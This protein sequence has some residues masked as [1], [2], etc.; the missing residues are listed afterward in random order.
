MN[1]STRKPKAPLSRITQSALLNTL[2]RY[3]EARTTPEDNTPAGFFRLTDTKPG[4]RYYLRFEGR[5]YHSKAVI[6]VALKASI[7]RGVSAKKFSGGV[8]SI[9]RI[10]R[11]L[12]RDGLDLELWDAKEERVV[13]PAGEEVGR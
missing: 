6:A 1:T 4:R 8:A 11:R 12:R 5:L 3:N 13:V 10:V 7:R 9:G 2:R